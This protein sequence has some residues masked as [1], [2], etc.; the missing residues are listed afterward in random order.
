MKISLNWLK[1]YIDLDGISNE[2]IINTLTVSG[3]EVD[4]VID[5]SQQFENIVVGYVKEKKTHPNAD[6]LSL[7][8]VND[9]TEDYSVVCGAPNVDAGQT[10]AFAKVGA[11]IPDGGFKITKAKIRGEH[12]YGMICSEKELGISGNRDGILVLDEKLKAGTPIS[13]ALGLNDVIIEIDITPN[14]ADAFSHFGIARDLSATLNRPIKNIELCLSESEKNS[15]DLAE[16]VIENAEDCPRYVAKVVE[17][18]E[19]KESPKWLKKKLTNIGLRPRNNV[20]DVT[21]FILHELGQPLHAFDLDHLAGRKIIVKSANEK[22]KFTTLDS[23]EREMQNT[24]LMICD[25]EKPVAIAGV[26]GGENSEVTTDTK[27]ILIESAYF[28][29]SAIRKT[30]KKLGL[31]TDSSI[32]FERGCNPD[33]TVFA[34]Q[35]AAQLIAELSGGSVAKGEIDVYPNV[36]EKKVI[37]LRHER[38]LKILGYNITKEVVNNSLTN[39]GLEII[40]CDDTKIKVVVPNFRH[41]LER[42]IDLIEEVARVNGYN[43][44]P[45]V[46]RI[47][48]T[49]EEKVDQSDYVENLRNNFVSLGFNEIVTNSLLNTKTA[50]EFGEGIAVLNPQSAEMTHSRTSLIPGMLSTVSKNIKVNEKNLRLFEIGHIFNK[51]HKGDIA[52]FE[53]FTESEN[54]LFALT[55]NAVESNWYSKEDKYDFYHLKGFVSEIIRTLSI[56]N[57][58]QESYII[59]DKFFNFAVEINYKSAVI[60]KGGKLK[61]DILAEFDIN[62]EVFAFDFNLSLLKAIEI[63]PPRFNELLKFPKVKRDFAFVLDK[64]IE[65]EKVM[66]T[67]YGGSSK[68]L[69]SIKLFDIFESDSLGKD[70][71]SLAFELEY[72]DFNNTLTEEDVDKDFR[73]AIEA[74]QIKLNAQL[75]GK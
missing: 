34:A 48:I 66:E 51:N 3:L 7:C 62:Q 42:E 8:I 36:I 54:L 27:N 1:E 20:V 57:K 10:I 38:L 72:Y 56:K 68:L 52:S 61:A 41:D 55:G 33:I 67:I 22:S 59:D 28:R 58:V 25:A 65:A 60:G 70:K 43:K 75:R 5:Q 4:D 17:N 50:M 26:M 44:I 6:K 53:D 19:I 15:T 45:A 73:K 18:V 39:L 21:N 9:G 74:V 32:R 23:K 47:R 71:K 16:V 24:D 14:R 69:K 64:S 29:P 11:I 30:A 2:E 37:E 46:E 63:E 35:R 49:L 40:E 13:D 12:S 31:S